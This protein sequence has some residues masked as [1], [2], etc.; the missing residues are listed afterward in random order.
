LLLAVVPDVNRMKAGLSPASSAGPPAPRSIHRNVNPSHT[1]PAMVVARSR[2]DGGS[3][4]GQDKQ[5][6]TWTSFMTRPVSA[7]VRL[8]AS[9]VTQAPAAKRPKAAGRYARPLGAMSAIR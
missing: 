8:P 2:L 7:G 5:P 1:P 9:G 6:F 4:L 3:A